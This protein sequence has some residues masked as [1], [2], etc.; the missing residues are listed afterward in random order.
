MNSIK[1]K[2]NE[3]QVNDVMVLA[4][5]IETVAA[6]LN[7]SMRNHASPQTGDEAEYHNEDDTL[8]DINTPSMPAGVHDR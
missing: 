6:R 8:H 3:E 2:L 7:L 1:F 5:K 4:Q